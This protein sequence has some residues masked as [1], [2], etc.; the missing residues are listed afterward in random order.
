[1]HHLSNYSFKCSNFIS[2]WMHHISLISAIYVFKMIICIYFYSWRPNV[3][4]ETQHF[5]PY[6]LEHW[7][8]LRYDTYCHHHQIGKYACSTVSQRT[9]HMKQ[10]Q[11][12]NVHFGIPQ[13]LKWRGSWL[14]VGSGI[15]QIKFII[16]LKVPRRHGGQY[17][18]RCVASSQ[19]VIFLFQYKFVDEFLCLQIPYLIQH[20]KERGDWWAFICITICV[21]LSY[22]TLYP[23]KNNNNN[24]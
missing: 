9:L 15:P 2:R 24:N 7:I 5:C 18:I 16:L 13:M 4:I 11:S 17:W 8:Y 14:P 22:Y 20:W 19:P 3:L 10:Q 1:M 23:T 12:R 6:L 21:R